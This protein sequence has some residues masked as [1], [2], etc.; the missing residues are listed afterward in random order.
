VPAVTPQEARRGGR[1]GALLALGALGRA[2]GR[3]SVRAEL[4]ALGRTEGVDFYFVA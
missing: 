4:G 2:G 1:F 3:E